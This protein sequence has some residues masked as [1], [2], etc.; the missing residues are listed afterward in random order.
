MFCSGKEVDTIV[1]KVESVE[2]GAG[3][4]KDAMQ[5][6]EEGLPAVIVETEKAKEQELMEKEKAEKE[7]V[8]N[9]DVTTVRSL[10]LTE[11]RINEG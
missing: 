6:D 7:R 5:I 8:Y 1:E 10:V 9:T 3:H 4:L 11:A 2:N